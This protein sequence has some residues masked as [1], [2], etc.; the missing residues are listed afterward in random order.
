MCSNTE[1]RIQLTYFLAA[2]LPLCFFLLPFA[3][4]GSTWILSF[5]LSIDKCTFKAYFQF[6][7][8]FFK[9]KL[10]VQVPEL[11]RQKK[12]CNNITRSNEWKTGAMVI[13]L[14]WA[15]AFFGSFDKMEFRKIKPSGKKSAFYIIGNMSKYDHDLWN[16]LCSQSMQN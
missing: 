8:L 9:K 10:L 11:V 14:Y 7:F 15:T 5:I 4:N 13:F 2:L 6:S 16:A 12:H 3:M 1:N